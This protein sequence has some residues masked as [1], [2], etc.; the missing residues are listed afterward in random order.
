MM[1]YSTNS[2]NVADRAKSLSQQ[3]T[4]LHKPAQDQLIKQEPKG[5]E[6]LP[7]LPRWESYRASVGCAGTSL[8]LGPQTPSKIHKNQFQRPRARR[9]IKRSTSHRV[10]AVLAKQGGPAQNVTDGLIAK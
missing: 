7:K 2:T 9:D 6:R 8:I 10:R 5:T 3:E 1:L 4:P